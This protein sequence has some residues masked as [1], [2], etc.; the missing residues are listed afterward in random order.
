MMLQIT[1]KRKTNF[2]VSVYS[3]LTC[4]WLCVSLH[5]HAQSDYKESS[6][7]FAFY[8]QTGDIKNLESAKKFIDATYTT[9]RDSAN[10]KINILRSMIYS[11]LAYADSART[12]KSDK[13]PIDITYDALGRIKDR[14]LSEY[15]SEIKYIKQN[16]AAAH[17][18]KA[19]KALEKQDYASAYDSYLRIKG[20]NIATY[21]VTYNLALLASQTEQ[22]EAAVDYYKQVLKQ[23]DPVPE[24]FLELAD[25]Y[26]KLGDKQAELNTLQTA[27]TMFPENKPVLMNLIQVF[28]KNNE[29][30]AIVPIIDEAIKYEPENIEL[31]YLAGFANET[32]G[33]KDIA[34]RYYEQV[35]QLNGNNY[36][37]NLALG[38]IYLNDFLQD[39]NNSEAQYQAQ[40]L[41]LK[42]NEIKPYD[43]NALKSLSLFYEKSGDMMQLDRV[44]LLLNQLSNN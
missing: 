10:S 31:N 8:T 11:S 41:L 30:K 32:V 9:R 4:A 21:D 25:I 13:D 35:T 34:K 22:Y 15:Q 26:R 12:I 24:Y 27:R 39:E 19:N 44:K 5:S 3:L 29:Y 1:K 36:E 14:N 38:L 6:N 23:A 16:L 43:V 42:A 40:N 28:A 2:Q 33:N 37:A 18:F 7:A 17:L 20:L